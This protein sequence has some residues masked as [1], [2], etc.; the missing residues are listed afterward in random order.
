MEVM[1]AILE[2]RSCRAYKPDPVPEEVLAEILKAGTYAPT[3]MGK[4]SPIILCVTNK[5]LRDRLSRLN[6]SFTGN[7]DGDPFYGAP[8]VMVVLADRTIAPHVYDGSLVMGHLMLAAWDKGVSTC[9]IHRAKETFDTEEGKAILKE[10][11]IEGDYEGIGNC[12]FG[13]RDESVP[14]RDRLPRKENFIYYVK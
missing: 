11:G 4:Q 1:S 13:Y 2:R 6:A 5:D 9:W 10:L 12:I 3:A 7:P 14:Y 8:A